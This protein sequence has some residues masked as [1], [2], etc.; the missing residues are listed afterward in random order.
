MRDFAK[1]WVP[2]LAYMGLIFYLSSLPKAPLDEGSLFF[3]LDPQMVLLHMAEYSILGLLLLHRAVMNTNSPLIPESP[4][5]AA[6]SIGIF[7]GFTDEVHQLFVPGRFGCGEDLAADFLGVLLGLLV[8]ERI[9]KE[10]G[11][12]STPPSKS[13]PGQGHQGHQGQ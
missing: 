6:S 7:Y 11:R 1:Y 2:V 10:R 4:R 12:G 5:L 3:R 9:K 8:G 13:V